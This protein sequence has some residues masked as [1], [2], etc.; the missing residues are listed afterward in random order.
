[1]EVRR[2]EVGMREDLINE[3]RNL[4]GVKFY[5]A[6]E[7]SLKHKERF[8]RWTGRDQPDLI[9]FKTEYIQI[10]EEIIKWEDKRAVVAVIDTK[11]LNEDITKDIHTGKLHRYMFDLKVNY[12]FLTN[13]KDVASH[14]FTVERLNKKNSFTDI[15]NVANW[16]I[17]CIKEYYGGLPRPL[18]IN[19]IIEILDKSL[20]QLME[21]ARLRDAEIWEEIL[22]ISE[23]EDEALYKSKMEKRRQDIVVQLLLLLHNYYSILYLGLPVLIE[24]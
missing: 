21:Y 13:Y 3:L 20:N 1:M 9:I 4:L 23:L 16:I 19:N 11:K 12:G 24:I 17:E 2:T 22:K 18:P 14:H 10:K 5:V 6:E 7:T 15:K 8:I